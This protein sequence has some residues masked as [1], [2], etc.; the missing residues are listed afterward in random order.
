MTSRKNTKS[1]PK[2]IMVAFNP[3]RRKFEQVQP[4]DEVSISEMVPMFWSKYDEKYM[5]CPGCEAAHVYEEW[6]N[7]R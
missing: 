1:Q 4:E 3:I 7:A 5:T 2:M 6:I